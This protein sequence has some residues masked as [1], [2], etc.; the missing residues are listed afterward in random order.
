MILRLFALNY[1]GL[2]R[3]CVPRCCVYVSSQATD[4]DLDRRDRCSTYSKVNLNG[5]KRSSWIKLNQIELEAVYL[6]LLMFY[7]EQVS[8]PEDYPS[9]K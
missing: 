2:L 9:V 5:A 4:L 3:L 1:T 6:L 7:S 8:G